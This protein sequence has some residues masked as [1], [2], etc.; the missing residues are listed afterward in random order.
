MS[1]NRKDRNTNVVDRI[2]S[3]L[4]TNDLTRRTLPGG[5]VVYQ[6]PAATRALETVG[7]R[8]MT[9]DRQIIVSEDFDPAKPED[10]ALFAHEQYHAMYGDGDGGGG[11]SN[12]RDAEEI[13]ARAVERM[14][15]HRAA[16]GGTEAGGGASGVKGAGHGHAHLA[17]DSAGGNLGAGG[18]PAEGKPA[19]NRDRDPDPVRGYA[20]LREEGWAHM[21]IIDMLVRKAVESHD[22]GVETRFLRH[23]D[24]KGSI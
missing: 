3:R 15:L 18:G 11:G 4:D 20:A 22:Q 12:W 24:V 7:A 16:A 5:G 23:A 9:L 13:A 10:Q 6:G 19:N 1:I 17:G 21:D 2:S 8:A 14:V